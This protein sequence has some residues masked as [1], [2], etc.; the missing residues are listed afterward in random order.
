M[1][2]TY[3]DLK[4]KNYINTNPVGRLSGENLYLTDIVAA[5]LLAGLN[6][7]FIGD[8]SSGKTQLMRDFYNSWFGGNKRGLWE[9]GRLDFKPKDLFERL[10]ISLAK[11]N[12]DE[13]PR[14]KPVYKDG[15][16]IYLIE[17]M[18]KKNGKPIFKWVEVPKE[19]V[20][21]LEKKY[22]TTTDKL[23]ELRNINKRFFCIDE[24]TRCPQ[25]IMNLFYGLMVGEVNHDGKIIKLGNGYYCGIAASNPESYSGVFSMDPAMRARFSIFID[26]RA[27]K[28]KP[29][30]NDEL[31]KKNL[32]PKVQESEEKDLFSVVEEIYNKIKEKK[33]SI[34]ERFVLAYLQSGLGFCPKE[35]KWKEQTNWPLVCSKNNCARSSGVC[36]NLSGIDERDARSVYRLAKGLE[37]IIKLK[38]SEE[39]Q[40]PEELKFDPIETLLSAY[41]F[42]IPYKG[43]INPRMVKE[44]NGIEALA[45]KKLITPLEE[46]IRQKWK[47]L[48]EIV[49]L[50]SDLVLENP[51][52]LRRELGK[53]K[54]NEIVERVRDKYS[55]EIELKPEEVLTK[56]SEEL[57][58]LK[59]DIYIKKLLG[60]YDTLERFFEATLEDE[61]AV[62]AVELVNFLSLPNDK[63]REKYNENNSSVS[64]SETKK[65]VKKTVEN[66]LRTI[67]SNLSI[68]KSEEMIR[69]YLSKEELERIDKEAKK[70]L[71]TKYLGEKIKYIPPDRKEDYLKELNEELRKEVR[72]KYRKEIENKKN[73]LFSD[74]WALLSFFYDELLKPENKKELEEYIN[75]IA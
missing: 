20:D 62:K 75:E 69:D 72:D 1:K 43:V 73:K 13:L 53:Q 45:L 65:R 16:I 35:K 5:A 3:K 2:I 37:E 60:D 24:Y 41:K 58:E 31:K 40:N 68:L 66:V 55:E 12:F 22:S 57:N 21:E 9:M 42:V 23:V 48:I 18:E 46:I 17:S 39:G 25:V 44:Y 29:E 27:Y 49:R 38:K 67:F 8:K 36:G 47:S 19:V 6:L 71:L 61:E 11:G 64:I 59:V 70:T 30:D 51:L 74:E 7:F 50:E 34:K 26:F 10:N 14:I 54:Y 4:V 15:K 28:P 56:F 33:P 63:L 32:S 52:L